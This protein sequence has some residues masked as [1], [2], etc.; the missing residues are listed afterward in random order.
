MIWKWAM[1]IV[2]AV[3]AAAWLAYGALKAFNGILREVEILK[4]L[5]QE[6]N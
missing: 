6:D 2:L 4:L 1:M 3:E 5:Y